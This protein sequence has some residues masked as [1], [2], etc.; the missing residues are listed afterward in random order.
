[1]AAFN[2]PPP[3]STI[4]DP[5]CGSGVLLRAQARAI[6]DAGGDVDTYRFSGNDIDPIAAAL[7]FIN[8]M[9]AGVSHPR[10]TVSNALAAE[11]AG[12]G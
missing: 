9:A 7:C 10:I 4:H 8:L 5:C 3:G 1:M 6:R 12:H 11:D 2:D